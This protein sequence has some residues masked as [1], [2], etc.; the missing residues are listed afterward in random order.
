MRWFAL[1]RIDSSKKL[2]PGRLTWNLQVTHFERKMIFQ[3]SMIMFHVNLPGCIHDIDV[4]FAKLSWFF[5]WTCFPQLRLRWCSWDLYWCRFVK[6]N[7]TSGWSRGRLSPCIEGMGICIDSCGNKNFVSL[8]TNSKRPKN[9]GFPIGISFSRGR[10]FRGYVSFRVRVPNRQK[11]GE[12]GLDWAGSSEPRSEA[13][14]RIKLTLIQAGFHLSS[15]QRLGYLPYIYIYMGDSPTFIGI[16]I[17]HYVR[18]P[19]NQALKWN[20]FLRHPWPRCTEFEICR[21]GV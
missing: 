11:C 14:K 19:M 7:L 3:T 20:A 4:F 13:V 2:H 5:A 12:W 10:F 16:F 17:S 1:V 15:D 9:G 8:K 18:I 21:G 6:S